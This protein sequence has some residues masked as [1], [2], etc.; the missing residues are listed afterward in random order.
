MSV[1]MDTSVDMWTLIMHASGVSKILTKCWN[2]KATHLNGMLF[3]PYHGGSN[4]DCVYVPLLPADFPEL[5]HRVGA[6]V[7]RITSDTLDKVWDEL[8]YRLN[9]CRLANE[10]HIEQVRL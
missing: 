10:V 3:G 1:P 2:R 7:A 8:T 6:A 4:K 9:V 5:R